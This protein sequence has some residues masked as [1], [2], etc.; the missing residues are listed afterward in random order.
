VTKK[1]KGSD[2]TAPRKKSKRVKFDSGLSWMKISFPSAKDPSWGER[3]GD[4]STCVVTVEADDDF[5]QMFDSTPKIFSSKRASVGDC[6][7]LVERVTKDLIDTFPQ[8]KGKIDFCTM[9]GP[10]RKSLSHTPVKYAAKGIRPETP[11]PGL[12]M[13]G[14][15]LTVGDSFSG[16]MVGG[17][18]AA[19]AVLQYSFIDYLY[20]EKNITNDLSQ[21]LRSPALSNVEDI[22]VPFKRP[23]DDS[24]KEEEEGT[25]QAAESSKEE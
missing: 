7:R 9:T 17:W 13:G 23:V 20:L 24:I 18:M 25:N 21:F 3:Y 4:I 14:S 8:L 15:D 1:S 11:Y 10:V 22:A 16:A 2:V 5:V 12:F 19:N 6:T